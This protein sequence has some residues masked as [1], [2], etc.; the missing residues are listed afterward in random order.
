MQFQEAMKVNQKWGHFIGSIA[1]PVPAD[2]NKPT[3]AEK[4]AMFKWDLDKTISHYLLSQRLPNPTAVCLKSLATAKECWD[5]VKSK[6]SIKSQY[7]EADM[8]TSFSKMCCLCGGDVHAFL[9][10]MHVKHELV[11]VS[12]TMS[13]KEYC[14]AII[15]S[16][17]MKC[18]SLPL[19]YL[20]LP[21]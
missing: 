3:D 8:L 20:L 6:F 4:K 13:D 9:G 19:A 7:M 10:S 2:V 11:A 17:P 18:Q 16:L 14:S 12:I 15:K 5:K 21:V 1:H